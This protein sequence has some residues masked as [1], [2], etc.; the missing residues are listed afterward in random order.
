M[1]SRSKAHR[2]CGAYLFSFARG[3]GPAIDRESRRYAGDSPLGNPLHDHAAI[4]IGS[5]E[6]RDAAGEAAANTQIER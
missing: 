3:A 6:N 4:S 2:S 1:G 5:L